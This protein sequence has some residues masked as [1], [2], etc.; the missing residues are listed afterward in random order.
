M[1]FPSRYF[2]QYGTV[3]QMKHEDVRCNILH[4]HIHLI[5][6][7]RPTIPI[8]VRDFIKLGTY[9]RWQQLFKWKLVYSKV[10]WFL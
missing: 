2:I 1:K 8:G 5:C 6:S 10:M 9:V 7:L 4:A 3:L